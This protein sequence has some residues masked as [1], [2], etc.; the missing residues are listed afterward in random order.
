MGVPVGQNAL[1]T[2]HEQGGA[3]DGGRWICVT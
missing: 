1:G 3:G 2:F